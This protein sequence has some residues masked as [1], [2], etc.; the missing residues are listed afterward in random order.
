MKGAN[1]HGTIQ[2]HLMLRNREYPKN[3]QEANPRQFHLPHTWPLETTK[4]QRHRRTWGSPC[5]RTRHWSDDGSDDARSPSWSRPVA[6][7]GGYLGS[8]GGISSQKGQTKSVS[9]KKG[10]LHHQT[11]RCNDRLT[12][13]R[14][15]KGIPNCCV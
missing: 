12:S 11:W 15:D 4:L 5:P 6:Q 3:R 7:A 2:G 1:A 9:Q 8:I 13:T 10:R 14:K